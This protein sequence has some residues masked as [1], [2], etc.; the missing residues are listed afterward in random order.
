[1]LFAHAVEV[2]SAARQRIALSARFLA[3]VELGSRQHLNWRLHQVAH[4][5]EVPIE[6]L[7]ADGQ[8]A[9]PPVR[10]VRRILKKLPP[11]QLRDAHKLL[12]KIWRSRFDVAAVH[13]IALIG[14]RGAGKSTLGSMLAHRLAV[15]SSNSTNKLS[16]TPGSL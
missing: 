7:A 9:A 1:V 14:L 4:A 10:A 2:S 8:P 15:R 11:G 3:K 16:A 13:G 12:L 6:T 5:L